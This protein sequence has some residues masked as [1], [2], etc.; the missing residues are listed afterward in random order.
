MDKWHIHVCQSFPFC[1]SSWS[2]FSSVL[3]V[4]DSS[5]SLSSSSSSSSSSRTW[6]S[7]KCQTAPRSTRAFNLRR[8]SS[9]SMST[10]FM[11]FVQPVTFPISISAIHLNYDALRI[12]TTLQSFYLQY[13]CC[14]YGSESW[15]CWVAL[16]IFYA[17][18][19]RLNLY[20]DSEWNSSNKL[21]CNSKRPVWY[22]I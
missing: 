6:P 10:G 21:L 2:Y 18:G 13:W 9:T 19:Y 8:L 17:T 1:P 16:D 4:K 15:H 3:F 22:P 20:L 14:W 12:S 7:Q 11:T 5:S